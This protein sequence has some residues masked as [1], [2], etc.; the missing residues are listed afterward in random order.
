MII[1][2]LPAN[3]SCIMSA[4]SRGVEISVPAIAMMSKTEESIPI[5][6]IIYSNVTDFLGTPVV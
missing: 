6:I 4:D 3:D 2:R 1:Q 5:A